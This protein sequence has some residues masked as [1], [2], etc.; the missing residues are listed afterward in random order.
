VVHSVLLLDTPFASRCH[1]YAQT[2]P[3]S[4]P[5]PFSTSVTW[6]WH[7]DVDH[8]VQMHDKLDDRRVTTARVSVDE[9]VTGRSTLCIS[10][11]SLDLPPQGIV[12]WQVGELHIYAIG[13]CYIRLLVVVAS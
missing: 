3:R 13:I 11:A 1:S 8:A 9:E 5:R 7:D 12:L 4:P 10:A 2:Y 6:A